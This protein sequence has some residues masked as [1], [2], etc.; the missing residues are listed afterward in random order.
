MKKGIQMLFDA[1]E[2]IYKSLMTHD[3]YKRFFLSKSITKEQY[4]I[5]FK[6]MKDWDVKLS[7]EQIFN[8]QKKNIDI[9]VTIDI[10]DPETFT[11]VNSMWEKH[12]DDPQMPR[13]RRRFNMLSLL[14]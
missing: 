1:K 6:D 4:L 12:S 7:Y 3:L 5:M 13:F 14:Y 2:Q 10:P 8:V 11:K 9:D